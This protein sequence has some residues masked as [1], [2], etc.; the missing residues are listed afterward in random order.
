LQCLTDA[1]WALMVSDLRAAGILK[2]A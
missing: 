1:E 2:V